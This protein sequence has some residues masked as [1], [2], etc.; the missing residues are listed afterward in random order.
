MGTVLFSRPQAGQPDV[1][2]VWIG[3]TQSMPIS[4]G[5][6]IEAL[7]SWHST[8]IRRFVAPWVEINFYQSKDT[9]QMPN[10]ADIPTSIES[11]CIRVSASSGDPKSKTKILSLRLSSKDS[12]Y[13]FGMEVPFEEGVH[14]KGSV[15]IPCFPA[16]NSASYP[17]RPLEISQHWP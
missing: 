12:F 14:P 17:N 3:R 8:W 5:L 11:G 10:R 16:A 13:D 6:A 2:L 9:R 7:I 1:L 4:W 15:R